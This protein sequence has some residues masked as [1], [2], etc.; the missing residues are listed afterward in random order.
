MSGIENTECGN[1][2]C[3]PMP[4]CANYAECASDTETETQTPGTVTEIMIHWDGRQSRRED[5]GRGAESDPLSMFITLHPINTDGFFWPPGCDPTDVEQSV[6]LRDVEVLY[7][8][9]GCVDHYEG[10]VGF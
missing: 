10:I 1:N 8:D 2:D 7:D 6:R 5:P 4:V 3:I 9:D